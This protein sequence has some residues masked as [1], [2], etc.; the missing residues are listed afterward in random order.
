VG[1][2]PVDMVFARRGDSNLPV[3]PYKS[4][5]EQ[6]RPDPYNNLFYIAV[7]GDRKVVAAVTFKGEGAI[8]RTI[9]DKRMGD[10]VAVSTAIRGPILSVTDFRGKKMMSFRIGAIEDKRNKKVF[11]AGA[12]G[13]AE[14]EYTG[15]VSF[16]GYP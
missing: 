11:G 12:D 13:K 4:N 6:A 2:N 1:R 5:G 10:P 9:K 3:L 14:F 16:E 7:R 15:E 8:Y